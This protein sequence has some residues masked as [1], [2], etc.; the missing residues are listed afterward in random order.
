MKKIAKVRKKM[1][2]E[3]TRGEA[4]EVEELPLPLFGNG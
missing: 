2:K 3:K 4:N 1:K